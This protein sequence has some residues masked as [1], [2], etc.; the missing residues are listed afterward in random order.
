M[1][2]MQQELQQLRTSE[3]LLR[4]KLRDIELD[5]DDLEKSERAI[6]STLSDLEARYNKAIERTA[7]LENELVDKARIEEELQRL[8][9]EFRENTEEMAVV[10]SARSEAIANEAA[11]L[12]RLRELENK[13]ALQNSAMTNSGAKAPTTPIRGAALDIDA[14]QSSMPSPDI[15]TADEGNLDLRFSHNSLSVCGTSQRDLRIITDNAVA[16]GSSNTARVSPRGDLQKS[17]SPATTREK[18]SEGIINDMRGLTLRMQTMSK[19]LNTR[20]E[21]LMAGSA[22]PRPT[23]RKS[24]VIKHIG[25]PTATLSGSSSIPPN[26]ADEQNIATPAQRLVG[27][28]TAPLNARTTPGLDNGPKRILLSQNSVN[29][30]KTS[31][32]ASRLSYGTGLRRPQTPSTSA[33]PSTPS[34][35]VQ[36]AS[37]SAKPSRK[38][39]LGPPSTKR[40]SQLAGEMQMPPLPT[41]PVGGNSDLPPKRLSLSTSVGRPR[42]AN[43]QPVW[44]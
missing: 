18:K 38:I 17:S 12:A 5:N 2:H 13:M 30:L 4:S 16:V 3:K 20:R 19:S 25:S 23:P 26:V 37:S 43:T 27:S 28:S 11:T 10:E 40:Y 15:D 14:K 41:T 36:S 32:P 42:P 22:I 8:K 24:A 33:R 31:R 34:Q 9:D 39:S 29:S 1:H 35:A 7:L 44:R 6:S 21:S